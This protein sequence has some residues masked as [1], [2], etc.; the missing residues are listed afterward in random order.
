MK[1]ILALSLLVPVVLLGG[2]LDF[3]PPDYDSV[4]M[5]DDPATN[6]ALL[7]E[8]PFFSNVF[9]EDGLGVEYI[10][11]SYLK[12]VEENCEASMDY[13]LEAIGNDFL[14]ASKGITVDFEALTSLDVNYYIDILKNLGANTIFVVQSASPQEF[15]EYLTCLLDLKLEKDGKDFVMKDDYVTIFA[16]VLDD[17]IVMSG[18]KSSVEKARSQYENPVKGITDEASALMRKKGFVK[19]YF[20]RDTLKINMGVEVEK[21]EVKTDHF[22]LLARVEN[23][24]LMVR[25][26]QYVEGN[27]EKPLEY[28]GSSEDMGEIPLM[29]NYFVG[30]SARSSKEAVK[31][32]TSWFSGKGGDIEK[33]SEI[34][35]TIVKG[36]EGKIYIVGDIS[37]ASAVTFAAILKENEKNLED[38]E[39]V[40]VKYGAEK[41]PE[42]WRMDIGG[43]Y[44]YFFNFAGRFVISNVSKKEYAAYYNSRKLLDDPTFN[45]LTSFIPQKEDISRAYLD[46]GD[47]MKNM[48][49]LDM[50][51]KM[52]F[53][54][55]YER[56]KFVYILEVM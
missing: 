10:F 32:I 24:K 34:V 29:G 20:K 56:G 12:G 13:F 42:G 46:L 36:A 50:E 9:G 17:F 33:V 7:K 49:G 40:L 43:E 48:T 55:T 21:E 16:G 15:L 39:K 11:L 14:V 22:E 37:S 23:G 28:I 6:Y 54:Q 44:L 53:F 3:V 1:A 26:D 8:V 2:I 18:S 19:G 4:I 41:T 35:S 5:V 52:L 38:I 47:L 31:S 25:V 51:S 30:I 45:Y 27:L